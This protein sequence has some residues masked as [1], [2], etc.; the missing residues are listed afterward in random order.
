VSGDCQGGARRTAKRGTGRARV[1]TRCWSRCRP[2]GRSDEPPVEE[3]GGVKSALGGIA[4]PRGDSEVEKKA[5]PWS[6]ENCRV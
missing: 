4:P 2:G 3:L 6:R 5:V 1:G